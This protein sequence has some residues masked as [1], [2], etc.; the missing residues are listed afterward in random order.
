ME[1]LS[2]IA[3]IGRYNELG[4]DNHLIWRIPED[5]SFYREM[6]LGKNIIMGRKTLES[7]P[8]KA[9]SKRNPIVLSS[10]S[11][12]KVYD[13]IS[14]DNFF[15]LLKYIE[16]SSEE[17]VVVGGATIYEQFIPFVNTMYLT[18]IFRSNDADTYFPLFDFNDWNIELIDDYSNN[19]IPYHRNKYTRKKV[20]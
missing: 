10:K 6:T 5:M 13:V 3:A 16:D 14:Y 20:K 11:L 19:T 9:L 17:F 18:E 12:D 2:L 1:N 4:L 15:S 7:M 8:A